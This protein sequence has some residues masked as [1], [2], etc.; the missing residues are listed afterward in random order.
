MVSHA[1]ALHVCKEV[2]PVVFEEFL[3]WLCQFLRQTDRLA[4]IGDEIPFQCWLRQIAFQ[5]LAEHHAEFLIKRDQALVKCRV[6]ECRQTQTILRIQAVFVG[7]NAPRLDMTRNQQIG[8]RNARNTATN[9]IGVEDRLPKEL[10][11]TPRP[12]SGLCSRWSGGRSKPYRLLQSDAFAVKKVYVFIIISREEIVE[13]LLARRAKPRHVGPEL[14]PH[15]PVL[16]GSAFEALDASRPLHRV[17]RREIAQFHRQTVW[18]PTHSSRYFNDN[19]VAAMEF[20]KQHLPVEIQCNKQMLARP[21]HGQSFCHVARL[22][23]RSYAE[24]EEISREEVPN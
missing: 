4:L 19:R 9:P 3:C 17:K 21:F 2:R 24:K 22:P 10:L 7:A 6:V 13:H 18:R 5:F 15:H 20:P 12:Y 16:S 8:D 23:Q 1:A 11:P 14:V